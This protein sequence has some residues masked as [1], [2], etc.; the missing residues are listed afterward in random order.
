M[1]PAP[2]CTCP[3]LIPEPLSSIGT[4]KAICAA[5]QWDHSTPVAVLIALGPAIY[6]RPQNLTPMLLEAHL[7][8]TRADVKRIYKGRRLEKKQAKH[9]EARAIILLPAV[10]DLNSDLEAKPAKP[11][12]KGKWGSRPM[13]FGR[14][15]NRKRKLNGQVVT[16]G[17][18][19]QQVT[20]GL[21]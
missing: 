20:R 1:I 17:L 6:N 5:V 19:G 21:H 2:G 12:R 7:E 10:S 8:K 11:K 4:A 16:R 14:K 15:S 13:P 3:R 18:H 9:L